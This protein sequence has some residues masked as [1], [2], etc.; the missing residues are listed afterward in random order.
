[1]KG[2]L[3]QILHEQ[4]F[5]PSTVEEYIALQVARRLDDAP[6]V[7]RHIHYIAHF[8]TEHLVRLYHSVKHLR[9]PARAFHRS[10]TPPDK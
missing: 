2:I 8:T 9:D 7:R 6:S 1:M 3:D 4:Q 5:T 10:L